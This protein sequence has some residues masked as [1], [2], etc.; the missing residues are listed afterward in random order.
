ML[1]YLLAQKEIKLGPLRGIGPLGLEGEQA[2]AGLPR[3]VD[4][5][6]KI[7]GIL[8]A[9]AVIWFVFQFIIGAIQWI[10]AGGD[11]KAVEAARAKITNA[12]VGVILVFGAI[13]VIALVG[14]LLGIDILGVVGQTLGLD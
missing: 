4:T 8:T 1:T 11:P 7:V 10:S 6:S 12:I 3:F 9:A 5:I 14:A 13:L 2:G